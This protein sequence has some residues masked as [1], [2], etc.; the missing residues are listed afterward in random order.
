MANQVANTAANA[1]PAHLQQFQSLAPTSGLTDGISVGGHPSIRIKASRFRLNEPNG[2]EVV[3]N[4]L[5]VDLIIVG[6]NPN[7]SKVYYSKGYNPQADATP[8]DCWS[9]NGVAPSSQVS[10]P[11]CGSCAICPMAAFGSKIFDNG[12]KAKACADSKKLAVVLA[13]N[14]SGTVYEL[15]VPAGSLSDFKKAM[16]PWEDI[17]CP[18]SGIV[19]RVSFDPNV[20]FPKLVFTATG[21]IDANQAQAIVPHFKSQAVIDA[22]G[23]DDTPKAAVAAPVALAPPPA[24][25]QQLS[26]P[27]PT[28]APAPAFAPAPQASPAPAFAPPQ[29]AFI[30]PAPVVAQPEK[31]ARKPRAKKETAPPPVQGF[32]PPTQN[33]GVSASSISPSAPVVAGVVAQPQATDASLDAM[34][35]GVFS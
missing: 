27:T 23:L 13:E 18:I 15:K 10:T 4:S 26:A 21:Y 20:E 6:F 2:E 24:H 16:K 1:L 32:A 34:L 3:V 35:D 12:Q 28:P 25:V 19:F 5:F 33:L 11:V 29:T 7:I 9:D 30:P 31:K 22:V 8:P 14:P 17:G